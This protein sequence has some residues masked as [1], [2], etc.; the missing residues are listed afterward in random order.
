MIQF[1]A[2]LVVKYFCLMK[3]SIKVL[4][5]SLLVMPVAAFAISGSGN[6]SNVDWSCVSNATKTRE[7]AIIASFSTFNT[8][9]VSALQARATS[10]ADA[11]GSTEKSERQTERK[12][13]WSTFKKAKKSAVSEYKS[14]RKTAWNTFRTTVKNTCRASA[15]ASEEKETSATDPVL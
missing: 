12:A 4:F 9:M 7:D 1:S 6:G 14:V 10:L 11:N 13:A 8:S 3:N 2:L 5:L 15:V